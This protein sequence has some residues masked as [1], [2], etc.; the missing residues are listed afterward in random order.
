MNHDK[1]LKL[2]SKSE[3]VGWIVAPMVVSSIPITHPKLSNRI[4]A[5]TQSSFTQDGPACPVKVS[6]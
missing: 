6:N 1:L 3:V 5:A 4:Q 2:S